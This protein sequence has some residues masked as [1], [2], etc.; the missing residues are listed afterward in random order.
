MPSCRSPTNSSFGSVLRCNLWGRILQFVETLN[1]DFVITE[2]WPGGA[3]RCVTKLAVAMADAGHDVRCFSFGG[4][5]T[6]PKDL[7][8]RELDRNGI[9]VR[10]ASADR[11][12]QLRRVKKSLTQFFRQRRPDV[13]QTFLHHANVLGTHVAKRNTDAVVCG[14]VRVA[15]RGRLRN[16]W[17]THAVSKMDAVV[18]VSDAVAGFAIEN[19]R[20]DPQRVRVIPNSVDTERFFAAEPLD[21]ATLGWASDD[22]VVLYV[23]RMDV[24]K[25]I[26]SLLCTF[27]RWMPATPPRT[28]SESDPSP[29]TPPPCVRLLLV[30]EGP[31]AESI[32]RDIATRSDDRVRRM[33]WTDDVAS[34]YAR[35]DLLVLPSHYEGMPNVVLEAMAA[36]KPIVASRVEG[37]AEALGSLAGE[38][39]FAAG[40]EEQ[41]VRRIG[42]LLGDREARHELGEGNRQRAVRDFHPASMVDAYLNVY[43]E[44]LTRRDERRTG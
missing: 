2:L 18:C 21:V 22:W 29:P 28:D 31:L 32:D 3:E 14:G 35:C 26:G 9:E 37:V 13:V 24:P 34:L 12:W 6:P 16:R 30:G 1:I 15:Q 42:A 43:R 8:C 17:E 20:A 36:G 25:N 11:P 41:M 44:C 40:D 33:G 38:Q 4:L 7:L 23:G 5:P 27:D 39:T 10:T 19:L